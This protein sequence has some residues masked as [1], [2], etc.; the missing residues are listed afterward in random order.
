MPPIA[1]VNLD[2]HGYTR[3]KALRKLTETLEI[4]QQTA[5]R[6]AAT[7][8]TSNVATS[9]LTVITGI[10]LHSQAGGAV[11]RPAVQKYLEQRHFYYKYQSGCFEVQVHSGVLRYN[12][13]TTCPT[14]KLIVQ[15]TDSSTPAETSL[16]IVTAPNVAGERSSAALLPPLPP[17]II[18]EATSFPLPRD[19]A[20][21]DQVLEHG[22]RQSLDEYRTEQ[23]ILS[24]EKQAMERAL[25]LSA[26]DDDDDDCC[27]SS[28]GKDHDQLL[29]LILQKSKVDFESEYERR[30]KQEELSLQQAI[31]M[32]THD[33]SESSS[34]DEDAVFQRILEQ[35]VMH[36]SAKQED[37]EELLRLAMEASRLET[38]AEEQWEHQLVLQPTNDG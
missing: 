5:T 36:T 26:H 30:L 2:L 20:R 4:C 38:A 6:I 34:S 28:A 32:S 21:D 33:H 13:K 31:D 25:E 14:T 12:M 8:S 23:R 27:N 9:W 11:L 15:A 18:D 35:S 7:T 3:E 17:I 37:E 22:K 16:P 24:K 19:V 10:G 29:Q 1:P